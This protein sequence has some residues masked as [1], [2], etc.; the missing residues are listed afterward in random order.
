[1]NSKDE[2]ENKNFPATDT[3]NK[4]VRQLKGQNDTLFKEYTK[5]QEKLSKTKDTLAKIQTINSTLE[6]DLALSK[7]NLKKISS[8]KQAA[9]K[10]LQ[11]LKDYSRKLEQK[12]SI[13]VKGQ[14]LAECNVALQS[15]IQEMKCDKVNM[16][17][18]ITEQDLQIEELKREIQNLKYAC[19]VKAEELGIREDN[20][21]DVLIQLASA[22]QSANI[23]KSLNEELK[24]KCEAALIKNEEL[25]IIRE[26]NNEELNRLEEENYH[27]KNE[28][29]ILGKAN[30]EISLDRTALLQCL[31]EMTAQQKQYELEI[32]SFSKEIEVHSQKY[33]EKILE[34]NKEIEL[35][36][37]IIKAKSD[38]S[39]IP[40]DKS[41]DFE[42]DSLKTKIKTIADIEKENLTLKSTVKRYTIEIDEMKKDFLS[43]EKRLKGKLAMC[44]KELEALLNEKEEIQLALNNAVAKCS[45]KLPLEDRPK[46]Q[47]DDTLHLLSLAKQ[48]SLDLLKQMS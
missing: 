3:S 26:S 23:Y 35:K 34:L 5:L 17:E 39:M 42:I 46:Q 2:P 14:N 1:M 28:L 31:E 33:S 30:K 8:Q 9:E 24:A 43:K 13:G 22:T 48:K 15:K 44:F 47:S 18:K 27:L 12:I 7:V 16:M 19:S 37:Q 20:S 29:G 4:F 40:E 10:E 36:D 21:Q 25:Q 11:E 38:K 41:K 32:E 6:K 45:Q